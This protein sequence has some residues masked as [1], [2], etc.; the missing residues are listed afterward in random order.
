MPG[1]SNY[2]K[3]ILELTN[4]ASK[5][6]TKYQEYKSD[7][8]SFVLKE[9]QLFV[10]F[11]MFDKIVTGTKERISDSKNDS[12]NQEKYISVEEHY[13][14]LECKINDTDEIIKSNYKRLVKEYHPD[15]ISGKDLPKPFVEF[16]NKKFTE[17][18]TAYNYIKKERNF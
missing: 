15:I 11:Q 10:S 8:N 13:K 16:A 12:Y 18:H 7:P 3:I 6:Y 9:P 4:K 5:T 2:L 1:K 14:I 17:I